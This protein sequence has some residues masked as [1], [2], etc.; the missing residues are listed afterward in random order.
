MGAGNSSD[1]KALSTAEE[2]L[3]HVESLPDTDPT[4][5][6]NLEL[7]KAKVK[8]IELKIALD[9]AI[10]KKD[11]V[12]E[13]FPDDQEK[14]REVVIEMNDAQKAFDHDEDARK[15]EEANNPVSLTLLRPSIAP[16][17]LFI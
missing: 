10:E 9:A 4:K 14:I 7:A 11:Y 12:T 8:R 3:A 16:R 15:K 17:S 6:T 1:A 2:E 13:N 5:E